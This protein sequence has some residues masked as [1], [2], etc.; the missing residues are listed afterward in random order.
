MCAHTLNHTLIHC[1][2][3]LKLLSLPAPCMA[4]SAQQLAAA[5][6]LLVQKLRGCA[7][8]LP[9]SQQ[10]QEQEQ[11]QEQQ[12]EEQHIS[13]R[14]PLAAANAQRASGRGASD[15]ADPSS[16]PHLS[17][18]Q[19][20]QPRQPARRSVRAS[21]RSD[22][23]TRCPA[24]T[25]Q[26]RLVGGSSSSGGG[27][28]SGLSLWQQ[29]R[30]SFGGAPSVAAGAAGSPFWLPADG[31]DGNIERLFAPNSGHRRRAAAAAAGPP[32][33]PA[34]AAPPASW[35]SQQQELLVGSLSA[36]AGD[37]SNSLDLLTAEGDDLGSLLQAAKRRRE[38][39]Q[40]LPWGSRQAAGERAQQK[41]AADGVG[42]WGPLGAGQGDAE[43]G[44][45]EAEDGGGSDPFDSAHM[46][47]QLE[48]AQRGQQQFLASL[49]QAE[50]RPLQLLQQ[51]EQREQQPSFGF[52][53][54]LP[55]SE[56]EELPD[57]LGAGSRRQQQWRGEDSPQLLQGSRGFG[58]PRGLAGR[59]ETSADDD[60]FPPFHF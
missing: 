19:Q 8:G 41:G 4:C 43:G 29:Q 48:Q 34:A 37:A 1:M 18:Q 39:P 6:E 60:D 24:S 15:C 22:G 32:H 52:G 11:E 7:A 31:E 42:W 14:Q 21:G 55:S 23:A 45:E 25:S 36:D 28:G 30:P 17:Q 2:L 54:G 20:E 53:K 59:P 12:Q 40:G 5:P 51:Q 46:Q 35:Q 26:P 33:S 9:G 44:E 3:T 13:L 10:Q 47:G 49:Q 16:R 50:A 38:L 58:A 56:E 27:S 57:F